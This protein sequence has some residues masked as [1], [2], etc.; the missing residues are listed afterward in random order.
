MELLLGTQNWR[1][2][3]FSSEETVNKLKSH[4]DN[5]I[6]K[7]TKRLIGT[8][9]II[10]VL[11]WKLEEDCFEK[12]IEL[13]SKCYVSCAEEE[14]FNM[15]NITPITPPAE[16]LPLDVNQKEEI[17][18]ILPQNAEICQQEKEE[19]PESSSLGQDDDEEEDEVKEEA[20]MNFRVMRKKTPQKE[21]LQIEGNYIIKE[22][23][24]LQEV[25]HLRRYFFQHINNIIGRTSTQKSE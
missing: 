12:D 11:S 4:Y 16:A 3:I 20:K 15:E 5:N 8:T 21:K 13:C 24:Y 18:D 10:P 23:P 14:I 17:V 6:V 22:T 7:H 1:R 25:I 9:A 19:L 2:Y